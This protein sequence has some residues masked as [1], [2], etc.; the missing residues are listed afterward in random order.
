MTSDGD[1]SF[2]REIHVICSHGTGRHL[3]LINVLT[4]QDDDPELA[5]S[6]RTSLSEDADTIL[7]N[8]RFRWYETRTG[9]RGQV[10]TFPN[11]EVLHMPPGEFD[12]APSNSR[13]VPTDESAVDRAGALSSF[14]FQCPR[15]R[16]DRPL[17]QD[18]LD[19]WIRRQISTAPNQRVFDLDIH[20]S[21]AILV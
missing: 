11:P 7:L 6:L 18:R 13:S 10:A 4:W 9:R 21:S 1:P 8:D 3:R 15:C 16:F 12:P 17:R 19:K 2:V 20:S 14:R 5:E